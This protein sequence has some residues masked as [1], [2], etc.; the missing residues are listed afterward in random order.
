M[1]PAPLILVVGMHRS[2]TSLLGSILQALGV[3]LPGPLIPGDT[4]NPEGY[5]E[6]SDITALQEEL[7]IDLDRWWPSEDGLQ[8][9]PQGW[10]HTP[11]AQRAA[12]CLKRLL[13]T[14]LAE[15]QGPWAIKDPRTSLLLP[16]WQQVAAELDLPLKLLLAFRDP[17]EVV[18]SLVGRD[19]GPASMTATR[20]QGLWLRHHHQL[21]ADSQA[22]PLQLVSY[23]RWFTHAATQIEALAAFCHP[24]GSSSGLQQRALHCIQPN[25]RRSQATAA[26]VRLSHSV[27]QWHRQLERAAAQ[28]N[29]DSLRRWAARGRPA[30]PPG[31]ERH[32]WSRA[33]AALGNQ[34]PAALAVWQR[35]GIPLISLEHLTTLQQAGLPGADPSAGDGPPLPQALA[36]ELV[37]SELE[38][39]STHLWIDRLPLSNSTQLLP[40][41]DGAPAAALHL[42][43]LERTAA[44]PALLQRLVALPRVFDPD[45]RQVRLLRLLGANAEPLQS[46]STAGPWLNQ[47]GDAEAA[48]AELGLPSPQALAQLGATWLCLGGGSQPG[49]GT[50]PAELLPW[51]AF[52]PAPALSANQARLLA[53]WI[54]GCRHVGLQL[55]RLNPSEAELGLWREL[56][57]PCFSEPIEPAELLDE[58]RWRQAGR[59]EPPPIH[60]PEPTTNLLWQHDSPVPS[61]AAICI[62]SFNYGDRLPAALESCRHQ[63]LAALELVIVDD[64]SS[65]NSPALCQAWL[66]RHGRRFCRV[67]LLHHSQN[68]GLAAARNSAFKA[69]TAPW[70]WVLDA[71]NTLEPQ[72][73]QHCLEVAELSPASTAVVHPLIRIVNEA[74]EHQG[75]VGN[76]HPWQRTQLLAGNVVDAMA[77]VRRS[78]WQA[79]GGYSHIPG[80]WED[81]DFWCKLVEANLHGVL[82]PQVLATYHRHGDSMLQSHSNR[83]QRRLSRLL[84]QRHPWLQLS[85]AQPER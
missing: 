12:A 75:L 42:Q 29:S 45:P 11:R 26:Q 57:V 64:A 74:G 16:L 58:L 70:C 7:L 27:R 83:Q 44:D 39:W 38:Q 67:R 52:P 76:G 3:A 63:S 62:S 1:H 84:Q 24:T 21:L 71:D 40:P 2:G 19:G 82:C 28:R 61:Q 41:A 50:P 5:F 20:A 22:L 47:P 78:A 69:A 23:G 46:R 9:L 77:L 33:L 66:E 37:G 25:H 51:P 81:F 10:L 6:R 36:L 14:D 65:D 32:P 80:G 48:A 34:D 54:Q 17:A 79:V 53:G 13:T 55:V 59:P 18:V 15:Q 72:A 56:K 8:P 43:P 85:F 4:H 35:H 49:W 60:T 30:Q 31:A 68:S 73:V